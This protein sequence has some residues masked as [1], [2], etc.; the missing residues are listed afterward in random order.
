[1][2]TKLSSL[3]SHDKVEWQGATIL[4]IENIIARSNNNSSEKEEEDGNDDNN[5]DIYNIM[6]MDE[7]N[8]P[9][10]LAA[11]FGCI[12]KTLE[13]LLSIYPTCVNKFN[14]DDRLPIMIA[15]TK[16]F[17]KLVQILFH[18]DPNTAT[19]R[20]NFGHRALEM[21]KVTNR[22][23]TVTLLKELMLSKDISI[24][25]LDIFD[26]NNGWVDTTPEDI[27]SIIS[28]KYPNNNAINDDDTT[29]TTNNNNNN[30]QQ[31]N[32]NNHP[33]RLLN[34]RNKDGKLPL[35]LALV[36][37][38][39]IATMQKL[40]EENP[41]ALLDKTI[42][43][44]KVWSNVRIS[45]I[46]LLFKYNMQA[47][48]KRI[49]EDGHTI[50][51]IAIKFNAP[52]KTIQYIIDQNLFALLAGAQVGFKYIT[53]SQ[54]NRLLLEL[55]LK[56]QPAPES[57]TN[58]SDD[59]NTSR[60]NKNSNNKTNEEDMKRDRLH[61][62]ICR[63]LHLSV[64]YQSLEDVIERIIDAYPQSCESQELYTLKLPL[65][66]AITNS[67]E[68]LIPILWATYPAAVNMIDSTG[69]TPIAPLLELLEQSKK[70]E[71]KDGEDSDMIIMS[72]KE[73][74]WYSIKKI[75]DDGI[76]SNVV[77]T[78]NYYYY[79][80]DGIPGYETREHLNAVS[81][82]E[83]YIDTDEWSYC[84]SSQDGLPI[85]YYKELEEKEKLLAE[86]MMEDGD[87]DDDELKPLTGRSTKRTSRSSLD[88]S[89]MGTARSKTSSNQQSIDSARLFQSA[90]R[91]HFRALAVKHE[92]DVELICGIGPKRKTINSHVQILKLRSEFFR[93][94]LK[95]RWAADGREVILKQ[96]DPNHVKDVVNYLHDGRLHV[97]ILKEKHE[98]LLELGTF[99][100][101]DGLIAIC[102]YY[103]KR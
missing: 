52:Y 97:S 21:A 28:E 63:A 45:D 40:V 33:C 30:T 83:R 64:K 44:K 48:H 46:E 49:D 22:Y 41:L 34:L 2:R 17:S 72:D 32:S 74:K 35:Y 92:T 101:I 70:S 82:E 11:Y 66:N 14:N 79:I 73:K 38:A 25:V 87:D 37:D 36:W 58:K 26:R 8:T 61:I 7:K 3:I 96:L 10:H 13:F 60:R 76:K 24:G 84:I 39:P 18:H 103:L 68:D 51:Y 81:D 75:Y 78:S 9:I 99:F 29:T 93:K 86:S 55:K 80:N 23:K 15:A 53:V 67:D 94:K 56:Y 6:D 54:I 102:N 43:H 20:N 91:L 47:L 77:Y 31:Q 90:R 69:K 85:D 16:G 42:W 1:M 89:R 65:H 19:I 59:N 98:S 5:T 100:E 71:K 12:P 57:M 27:N 4:D 62:C 95:G 88:S 50:L